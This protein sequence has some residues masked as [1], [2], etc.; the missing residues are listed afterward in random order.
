MEMLK[1]KL[2]IERGHNRASGSVRT[3]QL[4]DIA[5]K[6][7][8]YKRLRTTLT[9]IG[10]MIGVGA[11]LF[12]LAF[13]YGLR[14][15]VKD[16]VVDSNSIRTIDVTTVKSQLI[17]LDEDTVSTI[18]DMQGV[19][20]VARIYNEAGKTSYGNSTIESV[21]YSTDQSYL[22]LANYKKVA[23]A[24]AKFV[25]G[26]EVFVN[27]AYVQAIGIKN[28]DQVI[29]KSIKLEYKLNKLTDT[30]PD[31][32]HVYKSEI[33]G[34]LD[35]GSGAEI[36]ISSKVFLDTGATNAS[37]LKILVDRKDDVAAVRD[38]TES[39]GLITTSP[40]ETLDQINQVFAFLNIL[41]LGF[42]SIGLVIAVL[43]MFNTLTISLLERTKEIGLMI[44][45]GARRRD[46][47]RLFMIEAVGLSFIGGLA[48][49]LGAFLISRIVDLVLNRLA[50][51]RG[52]SETFTVF[53]FQPGLLLGTLC[54]SILLG[55]F[56][57]Y[58][59]AKRAADTNPIEA[60]KN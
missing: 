22:D 1:R 46:I 60:L 33:A 31:K 12:L 14:N 53:S 11:V 34:V 21:L 20:S 51:S 7:L 3:I 27:N 57:V 29:G 37:Q 40:L 24:P 50:Q 45:L 16:Q 42:G 9:I 35:T 38:K 25:K 19:S 6:N 41:F 49:S 56:V 30:E 59:P 4:V 52:V 8:F 43:G 47:R 44:T 17:A 10:V 55:L 54:F 5:L 36:Y 15:V 32:L 39:L 2:K 28:P 48:G 18:Q 26:T 13:G 23:G 58:I